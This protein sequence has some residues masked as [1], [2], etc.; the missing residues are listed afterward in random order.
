[1]FEIQLRDRFHFHHLKLDDIHPYPLDHD[2][3]IEQIEKN[4][5][6][7]RFV[8][9]GEYSRDMIH[10]Q[11]AMPIDRIYDGDVPNEKF[12]A[13]IGLHNGWFDKDKRGVWLYGYTKQRMWKGLQRR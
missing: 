9:V 13:W 1:M 10:M 7:K 3:L 4:P 12:F 5:N 11:F 8:Q 6:K 2:Q